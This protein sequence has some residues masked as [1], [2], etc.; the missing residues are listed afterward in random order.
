[1][2]TNL[3]YPI[4][5]FS[6]DGEVSAQPREQ[7]INDIVMLPE[8]LAAAIEGLSSEQL[9]TPYRPEGW[10]VRQVTHHLADSH[11]NSFIRFKLAL[12][13]DQPTIK[14]YFEERWALLDD[15]TKAPPDLSIVLLN[16]LHERWV[17]LLRSMSEQDFSRTFFHPESQ[18]LIPLDSILAL[19][20]WHGRHH[21]AHITRLRE[22]MGW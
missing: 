21:T 8:Q 16:G 7:W 17:Y 11:M 14:P 1:M 2:S 5:R 3:S 18:K 15:T 13:E 19:Y 6:Y 20:S 10:T 22:R 4:G 12:T 9:D